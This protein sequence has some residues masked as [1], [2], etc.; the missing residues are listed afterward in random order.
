MAQPSAILF[1]AFEPSGDEHAAP[2]IAAL[3]QTRPELT[4]WALGGPKMAAAGAQLIEQTTDRPVMLLGAVSQYRILRQRLARLR[5]FLRQHAIAAAVPVDSPAANWSICALVRRKQRGARIIH[6]VAPQLWAW[7]PWRIHKLRRLTDRVLCLFPFEEPWFQSRGVPATFVGHPVFD[8]VT[9]PLAQ[10]ASLPDPPTGT[11]KLALLPGSRLGEITANWPMM[12]KIFTQ[13]RRQFP[14][15]T[16]MVAA[17]NEQVERE[18][19]GQTIKLTGKMSGLPDGLDIR[20]GQTHSVLAWSEV[21]LATSGTATLHVAAHRKPM[22]I[23]FN[24]PRYHWELVGRWVVQT[25]TFALPNLLD[26]GDESGRL[27]PEFV[28]HFGDVEPV[29]QALARLL[30]EP[31]ARARQIAGMDRIAAQFAGK[32]FSDAAAQAILETIGS[33]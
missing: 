19:R 23:I 16:A 12:L 32:V 28:P 24:I 18:I 5:H 11:P 8:P 2:V 33:P 21:V 30:E 26:A 25:R 27:V 31:A 7:A 6:L 10:L 14:Q 9:G 17:A 29:H 4:I 13:L 15:M 1:T 22:V 20:L 3:R